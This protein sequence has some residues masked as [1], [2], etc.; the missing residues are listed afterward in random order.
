[1]YPTP[2]HIFVLDDHTQVHVTYLAIQFCSH[3]ACGFIQDNK[4]LSGI[5]HVIVDEVHERSLLVRFIVLCFHILI[6][7]IEF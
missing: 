7:L 2:P 5:T 6:V 4:N 3:C 1:M